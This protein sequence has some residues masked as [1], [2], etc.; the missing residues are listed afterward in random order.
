MDIG[1]GWKKGPDLPKRIK[2]FADTTSPD[3]KE[4]YSFTGENAAKDIFKWN[5]TGST[6]DSCKWQI[7]D[8]KLT[9]AHGGNGQGVI[10]IQIPDDTLA[11]EMCNN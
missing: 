6:I 7:L 10:A 11:N 5:C 4:T 2:G 8:M 1:S 9:H 3:M